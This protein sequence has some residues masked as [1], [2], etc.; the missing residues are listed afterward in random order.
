MEQHKLPNVTIALVLGIISFIAC[1]CSAGVGGV[2]LSGVAFY[3][4]KKDEKLYMVNPEMYTNYGQLKTAKIIAIIGLIL[5][6]LYLIFAIYQIVS[7]GGWDS[8]MEGQQRI[9][10]EW[11]MD[12]E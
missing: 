7:A 5:S 4:V 1:C 11:G 3:L 2:V 6:V 8:Y 12:I 10:E 9:L